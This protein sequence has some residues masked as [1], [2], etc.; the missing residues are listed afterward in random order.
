MSGHDYAC[1]DCWPE[2]D[3]ERSMGVCDSPFFLELLM[4]WFWTRQPGR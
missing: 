3:L 1:D 4:R 2:R